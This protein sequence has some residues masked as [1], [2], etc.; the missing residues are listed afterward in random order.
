VI[1]GV[2]HIGVVVADLAA[3]EAFATGA[4]GMKVDKRIEM[5]EVATTIVFLRAGAVEVELVEVTDP[6]R[7]ARRMRSPDA[8]AEIEHIALA[9]DD[10]DAD[11]ARLAASGVRFTAGAGAPEETLEPL[12]VAGAKSL[13]SVPATSAGILWQLIQLGDSES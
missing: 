8:V 11:A 4:L 13:F 9:V 7:R 12:E 10:L 2:H 3:A 6:D 1:E 5:P